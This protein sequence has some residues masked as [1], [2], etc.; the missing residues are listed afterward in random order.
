MNHNLQLKR[1][2]NNMFRRLATKLKP[3][4]IKHAQKAAK[5]AMVTA[6]MGA[7]YYTGYKND[8]GYNWSLHDDD[9]DEY[10]LRTRFRGISLSPTLMPSHDL[11]SLN[12]KGFKLSAPWPEEGV[13]C[14]GQI[15]TQ[16][17]FLF[18]VPYKNILKGIGLGI[19]AAMFDPSLF[20]HMPDM[21]IKKVFDFPFKKGASSAVEETAEAAFKAY[22]NDKP[23]DKYDEIDMKE[24]E[25][26]IRSQNDSDIFNETWFTLEVKDPKNSTL[27]RVPYGVFTDKVIVEYKEEN[28]FFRKIMMDAEPDKFLEEDANTV[29]KEKEF[30]RF[31]RFIKQSGKK[32]T[33]TSKPEIIKKNGI[34]VEINLPENAK[35]IRVHRESISPF[36]DKIVVD[37]NTYR[38]FLFGQVTQTD[39]HHEEKIVNKFQRISPFDK[40]SP[41]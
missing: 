26:T 22:Y 13:F 28:S 10:I 40:K 36:H 29:R 15:N 16:G 20:A 24:K 5:K 6:G 21:R 39:P 18:T 34:F 2:S 27:E 31:K 8:W 33:Q 37:Y 7:I 3:I 32:I 38:H 11:V 9:G 12:R 35:D 41:R 30:K 19:V 25:T 14:Y 17:A 1:E 23:R 4:A